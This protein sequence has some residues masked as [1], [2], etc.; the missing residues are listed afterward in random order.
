M[1]ESIG[2]PFGTTALISL[3]LCVIALFVSHHIINKNAEKHPEKYHVVQRRNSAGA[4]V[5][6]TRIFIVLVISNVVVLAEMLLY[7]IA[8]LIFDFYPMSPSDYFYSVAFN[9]IVIGAISRFM[10]SGKYKQCNKPNLSDA[11]AHFF[12]ENTSYE[13]FCRFE[14]ATKKARGIEPVIDYEAERMKRLKS[15]LEAFPDFIDEDEEY[16]YRKYRE[17]DEPLYGEDSQ[18]DFEN[19]NEGEDNTK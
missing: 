13:Q 2:L 19:D 10:S 9:S 4:V 1:E 6:I 5:P 12:G 15:E 7:F 17:S 8:I 18:Q 16:D 3:I 14:D 11:C